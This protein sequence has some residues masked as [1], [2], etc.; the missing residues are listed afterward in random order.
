[1]NLHRGRVNKIEPRVKRTGGKLDTFMVPLLDRG[2]QF[3]DIAEFKASRQPSRE[4]PA[5]SWRFG[6]FWGGIAVFG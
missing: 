4:K 2:G 3:V 1:M 6:L 5:W